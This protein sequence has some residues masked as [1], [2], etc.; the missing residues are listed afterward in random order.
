MPIYIF[1]EQWVSA[2][3]DI[4]PPRNTWQHLDPVLVVMTTEKLLVSTG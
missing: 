4:I 1:P 2:R 3:G